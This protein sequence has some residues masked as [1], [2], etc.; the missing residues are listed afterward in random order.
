MLKKTCDNKYSLCT[1]SVRLE[2]MKQEHVINMHVR[3]KI[4]CQRRTLGQLDKAVIH[5]IA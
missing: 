3:H 2:N 1:K 4:I 5:M